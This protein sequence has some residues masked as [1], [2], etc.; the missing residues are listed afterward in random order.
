MSFFTKLKQSFIL[1]FAG[2]T[3]LMGIFALSNGSVAGT[4]AVYAQGGTSESL[5]AG[6]L[7][8]CRVGDGDANGAKLTQ[9]LRQITSLIFYIC[10]F[11]LIF[12]I[13]GHQ[14]SS[15]IDISGGQEHPLTYTRRALKDGIIGLLL[16]GGPALIL[17]LLNENTLDL[18]FDMKS[19]TSSQNNSDGGERPLYNEF[20]DTPLSDLNNDQSWD[21]QGTSSYLNQ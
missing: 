1:V 13:I 2:I 16:I 12:R 17:N 10:I 4:T 8:D 15:L 21:D 11:V 5:P 6:F 20:T 18:V 9:C 19:E 7:G 14:I 3:L